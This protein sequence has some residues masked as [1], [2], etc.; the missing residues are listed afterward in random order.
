[1]FSRFRTQEENGY[2]VECENIKE[3]LERTNQY[4]NLN[5]NKKEKIQIEILNTIQNYSIEN[6]T[7]EIFNIIKD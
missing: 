7:R 3:L 2:I 4:F 1:M 6:M 5:Q